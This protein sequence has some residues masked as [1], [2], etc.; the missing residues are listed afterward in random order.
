MLKVSSSI[1]AKRL[2]HVVL[3]SVLWP[4]WRLGFACCALL[5]GASCTD[6]YPREDALILNPFNM[7]QKQLLA[8]MNTIGDD[9]HLERSWNY[10]ILP[11]CVLRI[12]VDGERG[13]RPE[14]EV[15]LLGSGIEI[16]RDPVENTFNV[17][18]AERGQSTQGSAAVLQSEDW[19]LASRTQLLLRVLQRGCADATVKSAPQAVALHATSTP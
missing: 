2:P 16:E 15:A 6:G 13:P 17:A 5:M 4:R 3:G 14:F 12:D 10:E 9:A 18:V 7:T 8:A 1:Q 19:T 11:D